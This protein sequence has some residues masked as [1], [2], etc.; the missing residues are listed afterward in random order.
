MSR[1]RRET[2]GQDRQALTLLH[3][4]GEEPGERK[5]PV[6][7]SYR[8]D[9]QWKVMQGDELI[10]MEPS[11]ERAGP[12]GVLRAAEERA[13]LVVYWPNGAIRE[14]T[15]YGTPMSLE[16]PLRA[17]R[18]TIRERWAELMGDDSQR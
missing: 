18:R 10:A 17:R 11:L 3:G 15:S 8:A 2:G 12:M 16:R 5:P 13:V 14:I 6:R 4:S 7:V 1:R 9:G